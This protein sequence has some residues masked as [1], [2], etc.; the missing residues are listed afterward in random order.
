MS[1]LDYNTYYKYVKNI[2]NTPYTR[3]LLLSNDNDNKNNSKI[4]NENTVMSKFNINK[5]RVY[6]NELPLNNS[7]ENVIYLTVDNSG[8]L[9]YYKDSE[10]VNELKN[11]FGESTIF[12]FSDNII[13]N[14]EYQTFSNDIDIRNYN[15]DVSRIYTSKKNMYLNP[16]ESLVIKSNNIDVNDG[17]VINVKSING[18]IDSNINIT[19]S[20]DGNIILN[21]EKSISKNAM[22]KLDNNGDIKLSGNTITIGDGSCNINIFGKT[23]SYEIENGYIY[24][25]KISL[26]K[27]GL[28]SSVYGSGIEINS[29]ESETP[30]GY[31]KISN[32][33]LSYDVGVPH[34]SSMNYTMLM[35]DMC[36]NL[37]INKDF[38]SIND[39]IL[40]IDTKTCETTIKVLKSE[41]IKT[42]EI[43]T[44]DLLVNNINVNND[45]TINKNA[46]VYGS[47]RFLGD[48][49]T[50]NDVKIKGKAKILSDTDIYGVLN[51]NKKINVNGIT[52]INNGANIKGDLNING[53]VSLNGE[54]VVNGN[55]KIKG[56]VY[57]DGDINV[58][59]NVAVK[60]SLSVNKTLEVNSNAYFGN[61]II[62][63]NLQN[64][65][66]NMYFITYDK[67]GTKSIGYKS[68]NDLGVS[69]LKEKIL[70]LEDENNYLKSRL[71]I[72]E[73]K[74]NII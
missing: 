60:T 27:N 6:I 31:I 65:D 59:G 68:L 55:E 69:E 66:N 23:K 62:I 44:N 15:G 43:E 42:N 33:G 45:L 48:L 41:K 73:E 26:N 50:N 49:V 71:S 74:L 40:K 13:N 28:H 64:G 9:A 39:D 11:I 63:K 1:S 38:F 51:V 53:N 18:K 4:I 36:G 20:G 25:N 67:D 24:D 57:I 52:S 7:T 37:S 29:I 5:N 58:K 10:L 19:S 12:D 56:S 32:D 8:N 22:I 54:N 72:I 2:K 30:V 61:N 16:E 46:V 14:I 21:T 34:D 70:H 3:D 17:N 47:S 35:S